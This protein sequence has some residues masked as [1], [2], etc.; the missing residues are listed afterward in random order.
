MSFAGA[1][2]VLAHNLNF[3]PLQF[4]LRYFLHHKFSEQTDQLE[5]CLAFLKTAEP[6]PLTMNTLNSREGRR[7]YSTAWQP[8]KRFFFF[9]FPFSSRRIALWAELMPRCK[10]QRQREQPSLKHFSR[11]LLKKNKKQKTKRLSLSVD[12]FGSVASTFSTS[13]TNSYSAE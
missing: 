9:L 8:A 1:R 2:Q 5:R 12:L 4:G 7:T 10:R 6:K 13:H 11:A 3:S